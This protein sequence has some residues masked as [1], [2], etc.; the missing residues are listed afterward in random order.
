MKKISYLFF[1]YLALVIAGCSST[2][3]RD[4]KNRPV[5]LKN[6]Q[7]ALI[8]KWKV[9]SPKI[10]H[11]EIMTKKEYNSSPEYVQMMYWKFLENGTLLSKVEEDIL[12]ESNSA[13]RSIYKIES[14]LLSY[15]A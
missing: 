4:Y 7:N 11:K 1:I 13:I 14:R 12:E 9:F 10:Y 2:S 8:G 6:Y 15:K 3:D 5:A